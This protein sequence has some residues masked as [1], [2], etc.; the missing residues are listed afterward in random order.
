MRKP[1]HEL[2]KQQIFDLQIKYSNIVPYDGSGK[3]IENWWIDYYAWM[4]VCMSIELSEDFMK[5]FKDYLEWSII[6]V[7]Q[8]LS[9]EF[10]QEMKNEGYITTKMLKKDSF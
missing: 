2:T 10:I 7:F 5:E 8:K 4:N 6:Y 3:P 1:L 9:E